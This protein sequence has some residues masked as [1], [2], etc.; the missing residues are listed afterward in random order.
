[1]CLDHLVDDL[2]L[3]WESKLKD[4]KFKSLSMYT[5]YMYESITDQLWVRKSVRY[6][7]YNSCAISVM[8]SFNKYIIYQW[9]SRVNEWIK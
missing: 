6:I 2:S 8:S 3:W 9:I 1:M 4:C 5:L 7:T